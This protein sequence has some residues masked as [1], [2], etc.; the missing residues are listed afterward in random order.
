MHYA[1]QGLDRPWP[2]ERWQAFCRHFQGCSERE[3]A[4]LFNIPSPERAKWKNRK[5]L[6]MGLST[7]LQWMESA[8]L[9]LRGI[10]SQPVLPF[11]LMHLKPRDNSDD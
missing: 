11:H 10:Q 8:V 2:Y 7:M 6:P 4:A 9:E 3:V 5:V 1:R